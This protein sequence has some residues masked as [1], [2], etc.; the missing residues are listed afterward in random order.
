MGNKRIYADPDFYEKKLTKV[1]ERFGV[2]QYNW[3]FSRSGGWVEFYYKGELYRFE[4]TVENARAHGVNLQYGSDAFAQ[5]V[6]ALEDLAR[7]VVDRGIYDLSNWIAGMK[8]LPA[9]GH[10]P[11]FFRVLGFDR[12]PVSAEEVKQA[13]RAKASVT[14]PDKGGSAEAFQAVDA[15]YRAAIKYMEAG[16]DTR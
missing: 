1:M 4:Q 15:A 16:G 6:L 3:D 11:E 9:G 8:A 13:Y 14:H 5:L 7:I 10:L 2:E 12:M